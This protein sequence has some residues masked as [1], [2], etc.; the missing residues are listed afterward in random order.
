MSF[1]RPSLS[2]LTTQT[3]SELS[4]RLGVGPL[5]RRGVLKV[6]ARVMAGLAHSSHGHLD[7]VSLQILPDTAT[8]EN[9]ERHASLRGLKRKPG[10][11][12]AGTVIFLGASGTVLPSGVRLQRADGVTFRTLLS[13]QLTTGAAI[14]R[15]AAES[16]GPGTDTDVDT[17]LGLMSPIQGIDPEARVIKIEGGTDT[18]TDD[19]LRQRVLT[20][21]RARPAVGTEA[22][23]VRWA[24]EVS[25]ITRAYARGG[26]PTIGQV[27]VYVVAD[28]SP[29]GPEP[30]ATQLA[31]VLEAID[32]QRP[33]TARANVKA[34]TFTPVDLSIEMAPA[35]PTTQADA[36]AG[37]RQL[38]R[39]EAGPGDVLRLSRIS[40][41]VSAAAGELHHRVLAPAA[42]L[43]SGQNEI[44]TLG[45]VTWS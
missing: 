10:R 25:G 17:L 42:D 40:E 41:V 15:V 43:T 16:T 3:E 30:N 44:F 14:V 27:T 26:I 38:L 4:S 13:A 1:T 8:A 31:A 2:E 45:T 6:L 32:D 24:L 29:T 34:P 39:D 23:Y 19:A 35:S 11:P 9:L 12:A 7:W 37:L 33:I 20:L 21:W 22:D 18:E 36:E 28:D 5:L